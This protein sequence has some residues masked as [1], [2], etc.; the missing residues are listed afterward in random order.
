MNCLRLPRHLHL[1]AV[2]LLY[3][4]L[5][6]KEFHSVSLSKK[7]PRTSLLKRLKLRKLK[8]KKRRKLS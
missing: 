1:Q 3:L 5:K 2:A 7:K 8:K 6:R 4:N